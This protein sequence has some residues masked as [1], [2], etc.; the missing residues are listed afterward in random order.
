MDVLAP[1]LDRVRLGGTLLFH[2]ELG[3]PWNLAL[4][5]RPYALFHYLSRG[6]ATVGLEQGHEICMTATGQLDV[7]TTAEVS[8]SATANGL[9]LLLLR[10]ERE[11]NYWRG[12][13]LRSATPWANHQ[14]TCRVLFAKIFQFPS[15][16]N[17]RH[18][19]SRPA[20]TEG[21][22]AI[23]TDVGC[24]MRWTQQRRRTP[25]AC[26]RTADAADGEVVWSRRPDAG[27]KFLR[28]RLLRGDG[29]KKARS[30]GRARYKP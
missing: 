16:P 6:S 20:P 23:V 21:R 22:F 28:S 1:M 5:S 25:M 29:G 27:V 2:F 11:I 9:I 3:H 15:D 14:K 13:D 10:H 19:R 26:G 8:N 18:I 24:G 30:P 12:K 17:H 4:P 7:L